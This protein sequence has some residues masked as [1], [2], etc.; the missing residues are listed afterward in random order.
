MPLAM[1]SGNA[2]RAIGPS[3]SVLR[4][5]DP[6]LA[7][8]VRQVRDEA[9]EVAVVLAPRSDARRQRRLAGV[10]AGAEVD[11]P[12]R[13]V[14]RSCFTRP[15]NRNQ[16]GSPSRCTRSGTDGPR[17]CALI[18]PNSRMRSS[19]GS[20]R[21]LPVRRSKRQRCSASGS[22]TRRGS[23]TSGR[24]TGGALRGR[25]RRV[26]LEVAVHHDLVAV[27][28][29]VEEVQHVSRLRPR[30]S[31]ARSVRP[32]RGM[33]AKR[34][35]RSWCMRAACTFCASRSRSQNSGQVVEDRVARGEGHVVRQARA[36][37]RNR[38]CSSSSSPAA[39]DHAVVHV[40]RVLR[41]VE[42]QQLAGALV[43]LGVRRHAVERRPSSRRRACRAS[44]DRGST[45]RRTDRTSTARRRRARRC[46][47][48]TH[49]S[50]RRVRPI[51]R[52][53]RTCPGGSMSPPHSEPPAS[54]SAR[55]A[56]RAH[57]A[58]AVADLAAPEVD[59]WIMPSPSNG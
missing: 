32:C 23:A 55:E 51:P 30:T 5:E 50:C 42:E 46:R 45:P 57:E 17:S 35:G 52:P 29:R 6:A 13:P 16:P 20:S 34:A 53:Q 12:S 4:V 56:A 14:S 18:M 48:W 8:V 37:Q 21:V 49:P 59:R 15:P 19:S 9:D 3:P 28:V 33:I 24:V 31:A 36:R 25:R 10:D 43:H 40:R 27:L 39:I 2:M 1:R 41:V 44:R 58:I 47:C 22:C 38:R 26:L 54:C 7:P 11:R